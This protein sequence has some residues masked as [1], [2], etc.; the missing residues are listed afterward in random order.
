MRRTDD[1]F[2]NVTGQTVALM[3]K[4][5]RPT[6]AT[7][8]VQRNYALDDDVA[9]FAGTA[10]VD[11]VNT[12]TTAAAGQGEADPRRL[13]LASTTGIQVGR[14]YRLSGLGLVEWV[15]VVEIGVGYVRVR[16]PLENSYAVASA[17]VS[18][19][20]T[21]PVDA[22]FIADP[23]KLSDTADTAPDY[24]VVWSIAVNATTVTAYS[25]FDV[26]RA[27]V[28][29][30]V[31]LSDITDRAPGLHDSMPL[32]Y[33]AEQGRPLLDA[34]WRALRADLVKIGV[35][36]NTLRD[37]EAVDELMVRLA[38]RLLAEGGW[39][40]TQASW[41]EYVAL[42][43]ANYDRFF[44]AHFAVA[45]KHQQQFQASGLLQSTPP[46]DRAFWRK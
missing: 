7:F 44:E 34:A 24:R 30:G 10:T 21:A 11:T 16:H 43:S 13:D 37:A 3:V 25:F 22:T 45:I 31:E 33:R 40:P 36:V 32:E 4:D 12:T 2:F 27:P 26:V 17:F 20:L 9:E 5:G 41:A 42:V 46:T 18:T 19:Y 14:R 8:K 29:Y 23:N 28:S 6:A 35:D 15:D 39:H 38:L 1:V